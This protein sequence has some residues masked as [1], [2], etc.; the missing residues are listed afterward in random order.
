MY[1]SAGRK[2]SAGLFFCIFRTEIFAYA[3]ESFCRY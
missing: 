2:S 1:G 3:F